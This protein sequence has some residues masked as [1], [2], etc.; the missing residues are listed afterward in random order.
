VH[1]WTLKGL[2]VMPLT[3]MVHLTDSTQPEQPSAD[4]TKAQ[5]AT[6]AYLLKR[7]VCC[8][9][10]GTCKPNGFSWLARREP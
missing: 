8:T 3:G 5:R 4:I 7:V 9:R 2:N 1:G 6:D 10:S